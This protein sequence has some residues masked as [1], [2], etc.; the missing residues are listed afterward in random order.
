[1]TT[2][3]GIDVV[4]ATVIANRLEAITREMGAAILRSARSPIFAENRDFVTAIFD[5]RLRM[6]A[7]T[8]YIPVLLGST[9]FAVEA[10][11]DYFGDDIEDGD[12]MILNDPFMGNNHLPDITVVRPVF[13]QGRPRFWVLTRGHHAD[14]GG[15]GA[16]GYNPEARTVWEEGLRITPSKLY[17]AGKYHRGLWT[18]ILAN[19]R[20]P[21]LVE[22]DLQAQVG[23]TRLG[24]R[25]LLGLLDRF[26]PA[27]VDAAMD[28]TLARSEAQVRAQ[29]RAMP[30]G[31]YEAERQ[32]DNVG[33][34][35]TE[36]PTVKL[37]LQIDDGAVHFDF[38]GTS[39][40]VPTYYNSSYANTVACC[41]IA[42]FSTID[43]DI[44]L[45][46]GAM[47]PITVQA[48]EGSLVNATDGA[49]T[50][51]CTTATCAVIAEAGWL[52]L[53]QA[54]PHL[55]Q[56]LW[57][58]YG[59]AGASS[60]VNPRTGKP[61]AV[62]HHFGKGGSGAAEGFDGWDHIGSVASM[63]G[64]RAP[65]PELF[66]M[67]SPHVILKYEYQPDS[68][69]AGT[70]R[71]GHGVR[72]RV[73]F[74]ADSTATVLTPACFVPETAPRGVCGAPAAPVASA[75]ILPA[76]GEEVTFDRAT[77]FRP[78]VGDVLEVCST[79]GGGYGDPRRRPVEAVVDDVADGLLS[80]DKA[81]TAYG[82]VVDPTTMQADAAA[83]AA[84][85]GS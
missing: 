82:V 29:L 75:R 48:P 71:G 60:G 57:H 69:G 85:R 18:M 36:R 45:N 46:W 49:A 73:R 43:P 83:T 27:T 53:A 55:A 24:E 67:R 32:L 74:V 72:Y 16:G 56:G 70:W 7:Q 15:S 68:A 30:N 6:V 52:A 64:S 77:L 42:L 61:F 12:V 35:W 33:H 40:Q 37:R 84:L 59:I 8:A 23:A 5:D 47:R 51:K 21:S 76:S 38:T 13:F 39:A 54:A 44:K 66:E 1:M 78:R 41:N 22:G 19:V 9:P 62:I 20:L 79:G 63:G 4:L 11:Q 50:T 25:A 2:K 28:D 3:V 80:L 26:G 14:I 10:I 58:R 81:R 65:D 17:C 34:G 31:V